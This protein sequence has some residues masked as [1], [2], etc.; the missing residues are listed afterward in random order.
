MMTER[1]SWESSTSFKDFIAWIVS[2]STNDIGKSIVSWFENIALEWKGKWINEKVI[3]LFCLFWTSLLLFWLDFTMNGTNFATPQPIHKGWSF[4][5]HSPKATS[6]SYWKA[7]SLFLGIILRT[8]W[9]IINISTGF[10]EGL[11]R[12]HLFQLSN[13]WLLQWVFLKSG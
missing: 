10:F 7:Y 13:N 9:K 5:I 6:N 12:T 8:H 11:G 1:A 3:N 4:E 2:S